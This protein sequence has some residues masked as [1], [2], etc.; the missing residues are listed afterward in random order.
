[1]FITALSVFTEIILFVFSVVMW[2]KDSPNKR[3]NHFLGSAFGLA[4]L[5]SVWML[6]IYYAHSLNV[7]FLR[8]YFLPLEHVFIM[9][10]GPALYFYML[11]LFNPSV[12]I[13]FRQGIWHALPALPAIVYVFYFA[14]LPLPVRMGL[15]TGDSDPLRWMDVVFDS[16]FCTQCIVYFLICYTMVNGYRKVS[17]M[18]KVNGFQI[19]LRWLY[20][21]LVLSLASLILYLPINILHDCTNEQIGWGAAFLALPAMYL[22][23]QSVFTTGLSMQQSEKIPRPS[24]RALQLDEDVFDQYLK[25]IIETVEAGQLYL[26]PACSLQQVSIQTG[27][28]PNYITHIINS[29]FNQSFSDFMNEYRCRKALVLLEDSKYQRWSTEAIGAESGFGN[30]VSFHSAFKKVYG[31][32]FYNYIRSRKK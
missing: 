28:H 18:L 26:Q 14:T 8:R 23:A 11:I 7:P 25:K 31:T 22:F 24:G 16:L 21:F 20:L 17:Y 13:L 6:L 4:A 12:R 32:S 3:A 27:I 15:L 1:M 19:N 30:R 2:V 29:R 9:F 5:L 10:I